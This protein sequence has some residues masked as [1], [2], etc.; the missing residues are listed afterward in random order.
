MVVVMVAVVMVVVVV[1]VGRIDPAKAPSEARGSV[2][3]PHRIQRLAASVMQ[4]ALLCTRPASRHKQR[5]SDGGR[6][7]CD[8]IEGTAGA[9]VDDASLHA[10]A[11]MPWTPDAFEHARSCPA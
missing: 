2:R 4:F 9:G 1:V 5:T 7:Y 10:I 3:L 6:G 8:D 11:R